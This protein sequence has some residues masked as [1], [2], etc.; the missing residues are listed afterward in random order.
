[1]QLFP[2]MMKDRGYMVMGERSG[3]GACTILG[4]NTAEGFYYH[5]SSYQMRLTNAAG[6]IIDRGVK[7]DAEL[8][9]P[10]AAGR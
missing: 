1:M 5:I 2:S 4:L 6:K 10:G 9:N 3:G 7:P 8:S